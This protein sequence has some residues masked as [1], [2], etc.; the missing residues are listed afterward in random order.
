MPDLNNKTCRHESIHAPELFL[1][2][3]YLIIYFILIRNTVGV[4]SRN[5]SDATHNAVTDA[6]HTMSS[7]A[8]SIHLEL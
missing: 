6:S 8:K 2:N 4:H 1:K 5:I 7:Y 3:I